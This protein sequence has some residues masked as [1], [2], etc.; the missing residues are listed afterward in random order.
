M[1]LWVPSPEASYRLSLIGFAVALALAALCLVVKLS[2]I[3]VPVATVFVA[4]SLA[5]D[6]F[7][8]ATS[9]IALRAESMGKFK[10]SRQL[11]QVFF[12]GT[13]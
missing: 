2:G 6:F 3:R 7:I 4:G 5:F 13:P 10:I 11:L 12:A 8:P 9:L 1:K